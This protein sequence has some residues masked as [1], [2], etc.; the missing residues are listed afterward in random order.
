ME[1]D[2]DWGYEHVEVLDTVIHKDHRLREKFLSFYRT[3]C[4]LGLPFVEHPLCDPNWDYLDT[5]FKSIWSSN[6][7]GDLFELELYGNSV[8][9]KSSVSSAYLKIL[10]LMKHPKFNF[11]DRINLRVLDEYP[12]EDL[13][14]RKIQNELYI[15][16]I[17]SAKDRLDLHSILLIAIGCGHLPVVEYLLT[18]PNVNIEFEYN[19]GRPDQEDPSLVTYYDKKTKHRTYIAL[20]HD[21]DD[22]DDDDDDD[23]MNMFTD[24]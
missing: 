11:A 21:I 14:S 2:A 3:K 24:L 19:F 16:L 17:E 4:F 18:Q 9:V 5:Y 6:A 20:E 10:N 23:D 12:S 15:Q 8:Y 7:E 13:E 1:D 22:E